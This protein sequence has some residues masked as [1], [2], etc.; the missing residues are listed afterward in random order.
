MSEELVTIK[1]FFYYHETLLFEPLLQEAGIEY[2]LKDQRTVHT[3]PFL[4]NAIGGVKLQVEKSDVERAI[5]VIQEFEKNTKTNDKID[6]ITIEGIT[7]EKTLNECPECNSDE[8]YIEKFSVF[9]SIFNSF[10][11]REHLCLKCKHQWKQHL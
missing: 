6:E 1:T 9:K 3:D 5:A 4:S 11:K 2:L 8:I 7:Y 10:S